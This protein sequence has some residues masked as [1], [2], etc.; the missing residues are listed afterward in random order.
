MASL[1]HKLT[2]IP[3]VRDLLRSL[4]Y[5]GYK[6][7]R[8]TYGVPEV[9]TWKQGTRLEI[10]AFCS[11]SKGVKILLGGE[12]HT[13]WA[14]TFPFNMFWEQTRTI[15]GHPTTKGDVIIENDVW[16]GTDAIILSGV[17]IG[18]GAVIGARAVVSKDVPPYAIVAGNPARI[19]RYRFEENVIAE[20]LEI[21]WW[22]WDDE[23]IA[24]FVPELMSADITH[25][26][27]KARSAA[28]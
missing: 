17:R 7:G 12:H 3:A 27:D 23:K 20:L 5:R 21:Q 1:M 15:T 13:D 4:R 18:N 9:V 2:R 8:W 19:I 11:I 6:V 22:N 25:F 16:I 26:I 10:G 28:K 14:S 24:E